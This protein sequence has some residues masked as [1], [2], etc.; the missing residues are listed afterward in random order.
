MTLGYAGDRE[1]ALYKRLQERLNS[2]P[3][4]NPPVLTQTSRT[5]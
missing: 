3:A 5:A 1:Q 2:L 4:C